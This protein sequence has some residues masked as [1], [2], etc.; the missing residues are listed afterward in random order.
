VPFLVSAFTASDLGQKSIEHLTGIAETCS[1]KEDELRK[2]EWTPEV[3]NEIRSTF[4]RDKCRRLYKTFAK[5]GTYN[6]PTLVLHRGMQKYDE[7]AF[8]SRTPLTYISESEMKEWDASPQL[9]REMTLAERDKLFQELLDDVREMNRAGV[10][11]LAGTDNNNPFVVPG[12][13]LHDELELFVAAGLTPLE[14]LRT[15]TLNPAQY[16]NE[17]DKFG[18]VSVGK[19]ADLVVLNADLTIDI[20]NTRKI[21][22]VIS[23][24]NYL[25]RTALDAM[26]TRAR[27]NPRD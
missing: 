2:K 17:M 5:N 10:P 23:N 20:R 1:S 4:D 8:R 3:Q 21:T 27:A 22:A 7:S 12:F 15:A 14:A 16:L 11:L 25:D 18:S 13:D 19:I 26:L 24:G 9:N 6:V